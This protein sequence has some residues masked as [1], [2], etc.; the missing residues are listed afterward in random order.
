MILG[1]EGRLG[2]ITE[3]T[4]HIHRIPQR[5]QI[6]GYLFP[7]WSRGIAAMTAIAESDAA[8]SVTRVADAY[9]T[10]FSFSTR[11]HQ[12]LLGRTKS[13]ISKLYLERVKAFDVDR[14]CL[15]FIGYE[16][17]NEHVQIQKNLVDSIVAR[18]GG[19]CVGT[20]PGRLY[21]QKKF[22]TPYLRD[23]LLD[24]GALADVSETSAP[25]SQLESLYHGVMKRVHEIFK[26]IGV[27]GYIMCHMAH[28]YHAGACLYFTF[29][30]RP[31]DPLHSLQEYARVKSTIQQAFM[32]SGG[33]LSHHHGVGVEHVPWLSQDI[34][35]VGVTIIRSLLDG[36]DPGHNLNPGKI[37]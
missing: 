24:R 27:K 18:H 2:I 35:P 30:F 25:W 26:Q 10:Q 31:T 22:Y 28:S 11:K 8:P 6:L 36:V 15:S 21:D 3:A 7:D 13:A 17:S 34:S 4:V 29:A 16:G 14:M 20:S 32:D 1:S 33:T 9:E 37:V 23:F 19:I 5:R 12:G